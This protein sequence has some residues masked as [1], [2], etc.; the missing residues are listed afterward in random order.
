MS[1]NEAFN[2]PIE[3]DYVPG[4]YSE[5]FAEEVLKEKLSDQ[6]WRL[7]NLYKVKD[8]RGNVVTFVMNKAQEKL[9]DT[10]HFKNIILKARQLGFTTFIDLYIL[11]VCLF[12]DTINAGIIAHHMDDAK[13]IFEEKVRFPYDNLDPRIRAERMATTDR[14]NEIR[15]S[16]GSRIRVS[17]SFRSGTVQILHIS[18]FGK[19]AAK[20]PDKA[21]EI[22]SGAMEAVPLDGLLFVEST[23]EGREG[24]FYDMTMVAKRLHDD[25]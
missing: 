11:D 2:T 16:N 21:I 5:E 8:K 19:I 1:Q 13:T 17:T 15:F 14:A 10:M 3:E 12:N 25:A 7:N 20:Y 23:A 6:K 22:I 9:F 4:Q 24:A 18:E